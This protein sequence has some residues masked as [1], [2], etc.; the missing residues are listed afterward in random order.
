MGSS[1]R[2][3]LKWNFNREKEPRKARCSSK[4]RG[5]VPSGRYAA[6]C[7]TIDTGCNERRLLSLMSS[8]ELIPELRH[9]GWHDGPACREVTYSAIID[10]SLRAI[11][12]PVISPR[13]DVA[14][15]YVSTPALVQLSNAGSR[16]IRQCAAYLDKSQFRQCR[17]VALSRGRHSQSV[18][19]DIA[20]HPSEADG[21]LEIEF[22]Q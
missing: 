10:E 1:G 2:A 14:T 3:G 17:K 9:C 13:C 19:P 16:K 8:S 7:R 22:R 12:T 15:S 4:G 21:G 18:G 6:L 20:H 11:S 5:K